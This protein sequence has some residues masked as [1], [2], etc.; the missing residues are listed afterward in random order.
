M[1]TWPGDRIGCGGCH[2]PTQWSAITMSSTFVQTSSKLES[3]PENQNGLTSTNSVA[4]ALSKSV[5]AS[6]LVAR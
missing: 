1:C 4:S 6:G 5:T 3:K 2:A